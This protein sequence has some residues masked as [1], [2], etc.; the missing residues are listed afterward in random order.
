[1]QNLNLSCLHPESRHPETQ[2]LFERLH[3]YLPG[4]TSK[5]TRNWEILCLLAIEKKNSELKHRDRSKALISP[6]LNQKS[7]TNANDP[8]QGPES[9]LTALPNLVWNW[10]KVLPQT[11]FD[12]IDLKQEKRI[13]ACAEKGDCSVWILDLVLPLKDVTRTVKA[14]PFEEFPK[15][16]A[17]WAETLDISNSDSPQWQSKWLFLGIP[18]WDPV[19]DS[20]AFIRSSI[21]DTNK[22][23]FKTRWTKVNLP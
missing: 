16:F 13:L 5:P 7:L 20:L 11:N 23:E 21:Q 1:M 19:K 10:K 3:K 18:E 6:S 12:R 17:V 15:A 14:L 22:S 9:P 4:A 8:A 2:S